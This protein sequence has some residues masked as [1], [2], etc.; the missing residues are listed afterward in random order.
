[1][2]HRATLALFISVLTPS[3]DLSHMVIYFLLITCLPLPTPLS[4]RVGICA[5]TVDWYMPA[6]LEASRHPTNASKLNF[7]YWELRT[8]HWD[9]HFKVQ[10]SQ[11]LAREMHLYFLKP[12][13]RIPRKPT[14]CQRSHS[15]SG[16]SEAQAG[17]GVVSTCLSTLLGAWTVCDIVEQRFQNPMCCVTASL[18]RP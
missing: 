8:W 17:P 15:L 13:S 4:S 18:K 14:T 1:M 7:H 16:Q 2:P 12:D 3:T 9:R 10:L 11:S 6:R 5:S